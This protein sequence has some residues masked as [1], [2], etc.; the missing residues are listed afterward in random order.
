MKSKSKIVVHGGLINLYNRYYIR[1]RYV[2]EK[3]QKRKAKYYNTGLE[4]VP[5]NK[6]Q[7]QQMLWDKRKEFEEEI[8]STYVPLDKNIPFHLFMAKWIENLKEMNELEV[9]TIEGYERIVNN[10]IVPYFEKK[11]MS[12]SEIRVMDLE[13]FYAYLG[14]KKNLSPAT[15]H[16]V[17]V[18]IN[19]AMAEAVRQDLIKL[20]PSEYVKLPKARKYSAKTLTVQEWKQIPEIF[21]GEIIEIPVLLTA[22]CGLRRSEVLALKWSDYDDNNSLLRIRST[23]VPV[24]GKIMEKDRCKNASSIRY[25]YVP[26]LIAKRLT[27]WKERQLKYRKQFGK[28]YISVIDEKDN[29]YICTWPD[30]HLI[31]PNYI[32]HRFRTVID[33]SDLPKIRFHDLRHTLAT[34]LNE[35]GAP[36]KEIQELLG[37]S[38]ISTTSNIYIHFT[39]K[40]A[41]EIAVMTQN[42]IK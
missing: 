26:D 28:K 21:K 23:R 20:C 29:D 6:M 16:R 8:N 30:G 5:K 22:F 10:H 42:L 14:A 1:L 13:T 7:A 18:T 40:E 38:N 35:N 41:K 19:K 31:D 24:K 32:S 33:E 34:I 3:G 25:L 15:V 17:H 9:N 11:Q 37:H 4:Y 12:L 36:L 27:E 39:K 2:C